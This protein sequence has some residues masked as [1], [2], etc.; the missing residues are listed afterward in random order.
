MISIS[1]ILVS[2]AVA[3][4]AG[5]ITGVIMKTGFG[6]LWSIVLGLIGGVVGNAVLALIDLHANGIIGNIV[7]AVIGACIVL[8]VAKLAKK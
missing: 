8:G 5:W 4:I 6:L 1:G 7:A 2:L 3:A